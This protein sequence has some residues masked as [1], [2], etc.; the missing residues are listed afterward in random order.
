MAGQKVYDCGHKENMVVAGQKV[1]V[2][3]KGIWLWP[4]RRCMTVATKRI[5]L[6]PNIRWMDDC[7]HTWGV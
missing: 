6:W 2:D 4:D 3:T 1:Y 5:L 7:G